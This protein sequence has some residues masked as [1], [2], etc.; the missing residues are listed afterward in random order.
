M[1]DVK[2]RKELIRDPNL[3]VPIAFDDVFKV[4]FGTEENSDI[5]AYLVSL[6]LKIPYEKVEG[7]I[8]FKSPRQKNY[9]VRDK[10]SE[11]DIVFLVDTSVPLRINL[12]M[13]RI[14]TIGKSLIDRN[15][16]YEAN[17]F[18]SGF[19]S[20]NEYK[21]L[22]MTIQ[23]NF[24]LDYVDKVE[25]P[26][27]DE[28]LFRNERGNVL[29]D[30]TKIVHIN[31][32]KMADL[33]YNKEYKKF[34]EINPELFGLFSLILENEKRKFTYLVG[35]V[36]MKKRI[37][38]K[39]ERVVMDMNADDE[40]VTKYYDLEEERHKM[41]AALVEDAKEIFKEQGIQEGIKEGVQ[42]GIEEGIKEGSQKK[43][44]EI[45]LNMYQNNLT[46]EQIAKYT[47]LTLEE[48][49]EILE[50]VKSKN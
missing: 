33:W 31:I 22:K 41:Y 8:I 18:G 34:K 27:I 16:Y 4:V 35:D 3:L 37:R 19:Q 44:T 12:E 2:N 36:P 43:Q 11:K 39:L 48:V 50:Q 13:N 40:L 9:K 17:L 47:G 45:V 10:R 5:T 46:M 7:K 42:Q 29:T 24:N 23:Y 30:K 28:Y 49:K 25:E 26:L 15:A 14:E 20:Q 32:K 6:L 38:E 21:D 1:N